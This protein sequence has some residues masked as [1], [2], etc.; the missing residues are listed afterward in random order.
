MP[1]VSQHPALILTAEEKEQ[2]D[3][4]LPVSVRNRPRQL[5]RSCDSG[6]LAEEQP[7]SHA[8]VTVHLGL[9]GRG[10]HQVAA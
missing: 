4:E 8:D 7:D 2:L 10:R 6:Q 9:P 1:G 3:R 5:A